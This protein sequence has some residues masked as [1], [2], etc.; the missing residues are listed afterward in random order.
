M[1]VNLELDVGPLSEAQTVGVGVR[2]SG[3][4]AKHSKQS[5]GACGREDSPC[6]GRGTLRWEGWSATSTAAAKRA[7]KIYSIS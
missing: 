7:G 4:E 6:Q 3:N 2:A 5:K 1:R